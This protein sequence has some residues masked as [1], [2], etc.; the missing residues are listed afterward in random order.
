MPPEPDKHFG[1]AYYTPRNILQVAFWKQSHV[2]WENFHRMVH[3]HQTTSCLKQYQERLP[4]M[5]N[6]A[7]PHIM[8]QHLPSLD[9]P[10]YS[11]SQR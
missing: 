10:E 9:V 2:G 6:K 8:G 3:I 7:Y 4:G 11:T 5:V 1:T